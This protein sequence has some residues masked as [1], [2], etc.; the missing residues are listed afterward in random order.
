MVQVKFVEDSFFK[1]LK[2]YVS[3]SY[4]LKMFKYCLPQILLGPFLNTLPQLLSFFLTSLS[5]HFR[6]VFSEGIEREH[7]TGMC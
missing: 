3:R 4:P 2:G 7:G 5:A 1:N 6:I